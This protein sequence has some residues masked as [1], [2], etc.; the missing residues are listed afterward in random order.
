MDSFVCIHWESNP[1]WFIS[2]WMERSN[3]MVIQYGFIWFQFSDRWTYCMYSRCTFI[4]CNDYPVELCAIWFEIIDFV[5]YHCHQSIASNLESGSRTTGFTN[6]CI[7]W[8]ELESR[9]W[10]K[11]QNAPNLVYFPGI[12]VSWHCLV[13]FVVSGTGLLNL[14]YF[15]NTA[16][17][18]KR[19]Q[20]VR[21]WS[22]RGMSSL[23]VNLWLISHILSYHRD[24]CLMI[25]RRCDRISKFRTFFRGLQD[26]GYYEIGWDDRSE[27]L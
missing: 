5:P 6:S 9:R 21:C 13:S 20:T 12:S 22:V 24:C 3:S 11:R 10:P 4:M 17:Y 19:S 2:F 8:R 25:S 23:W 7:T 26:C 1:L 15:Q 27:A 16:G 14:M 18:L